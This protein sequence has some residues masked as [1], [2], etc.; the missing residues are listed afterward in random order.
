MLL[1]A[2][3]RPCATDHQPSAWLHWLMLLATSRGRAA[4]LGM[5]GAAMMRAHSM[6]ALL[7]LLGAL[8]L[9]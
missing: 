4:L 9:H 7:G 3:H 5:P 2:G 8:M 1:P 6:T